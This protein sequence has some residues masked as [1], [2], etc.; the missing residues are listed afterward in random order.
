LPPRKQL[1]ALA[2]I[3]PQ[4]SREAIDKLKR[5]AKQEPENAWKVSRAYL[6]RSPA[7]LGAA[8]VETIVA[9]LDDDIHYPI[10]DSQWAEC[11]R[12]FFIL[13]GKDDSF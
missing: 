4:E 13:R 3:I 6:Q 11:H 12:T 5:M 2:D 7:R 10:L 9:M 1:P 8:Q